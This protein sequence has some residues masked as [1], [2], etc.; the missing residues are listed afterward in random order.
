MR[1]TFKIKYIKNTFKSIAVGTCKH[2]MKEYSKMGKHVNP[3]WHPVY[4][5]MNMLSNTCDVFGFL[6]KRLYVMI[7]SHSRANRYVSYETTFVFLCHKWNRAIWCYASAI[8]SCWKIHIGIGQCS[9][10]D[11]ALNCY[12]TKI[13]RAPRISHRTNMKRDKREHSEH[14][15]Y[16]Q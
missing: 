2:A 4:Y 11:L 3:L 9:A 12:F 1:T 15:Q 10:Y 8:V 14:I 7:N 13:K 6:L 5:N 16:C